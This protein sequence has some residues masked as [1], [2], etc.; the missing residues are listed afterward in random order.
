[1]SWTLGE[2]TPMRP[3]AS[4]ERVVSYVRIL[5]S[6]AAILAR[7]GCEAHGELVRDLALRIRDGDPPSILVTT[8]FWGGSGSVV[9]CSI[10]GGPGPS[11]D[12]LTDEQRFCEALVALADLLT[13]DGVAD[14]LVRS[15]RQ[16]FSFWAGQRNT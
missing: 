1:V 10:L 14:S 9:D 5:D 3:Q 13:Q 16:T 7:N 6:L 4:G 8:D 15:R 11:T 12:T 2:V